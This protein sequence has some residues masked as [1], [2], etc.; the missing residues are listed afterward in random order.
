MSYQV[1]DRVVYTGDSRMSTGTIIAIE[2]AT[3]LYGTEYAEIEWDSDIQFAPPKKLPAVYLAYFNDGSTMSIK[4]EC[5]V[6][7]V[8]DGG[9]HSS[10]CPMSKSKDIK[11]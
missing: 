8:R 5:G 3:D 1:G 9:I 2:E 7:F 6:S 4:C 10:W 11:I